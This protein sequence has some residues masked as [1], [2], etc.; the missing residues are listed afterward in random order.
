VARTLAIPPGHRHV[1]AVAEPEAAFGPDLH[2]TRGQIASVLHRV[3]TDADLDPTGP[4]GTFLDELGDTH[5]T[6]IGALAGAG[7]LN[8]YTDATF[9]PNDPIQ[10]GQAASFLAR[11][12]T[13]LDR[14]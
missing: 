12:L 9:G 8:G 11:W 13:G 10:R 5:G 3:L 2:L 7:I 14:T 6:A 1:R 4:A